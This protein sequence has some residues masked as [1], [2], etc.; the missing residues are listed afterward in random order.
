MIFNSCDFYHPSVKEVPIMET[1]SSEQFRY[2]RLNSHHL[3]RFYKSS[4]ILALAG[5]CGFQNSPPGAWESALHFRAPGLSSDGMNRLLY[6]E[7]TLLQA[8]SFRGAPVVFPSCESGTFLLA[9]AACPGESWIYTKGITLALDYLEMDEEELLKLLKEVMPGLDDT[10][11]VSKSTLDQTLARWMLPLLPPDRRDRWM[12]P[13]MYGDPGRQ[14]V[15]GAVV[16]FLLRP[17]SF[18]GLVVFGERQ[19]Q[20]PTFTSLKRWTGSGLSPQPDAAKQ[21]VRKYLHCYGPSTPGDFAAWL[22]ASGQQARRMWQEVRPEMEPAKISGK[23]VWYL[24]NDREA[25][26]APADPTRNLLLTDGHDPYLDQRDRWI[27]QPD[28]AL[29]RKIW[30]TVA[31]PGTVIWQGEII[32]IWNGRR[33]SRGLNIHMDIWKNPF[34][35]E[36]ELRRMLEDHVAE[37]AAFRQLSL[38]D[39]SISL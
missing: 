14:T 9:L 4:D 33:S 16:S 8:W 38:S 31:N 10:V 18:L 12:A 37:Y 27:L 20:F 32:G 39:F 11:L 15:G 6:Q 28:K 22:G 25:L 13:S 2:F 26:F 1:L 19:N 7:R 23:T 34:D 21:L 35:T 3:D 17:C 36:E 24:S 30:R 5:A 29:H